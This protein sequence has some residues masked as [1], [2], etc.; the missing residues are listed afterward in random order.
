VENELR[1]IMK[2][3]GLIPK[4]KS[5]RLHNMVTNFLEGA[6]K[7]GY[8]T[9]TR[10]ITKST[11]VNKINVNNFNLVVSSGWASYVNKIINHYKVPNIVI[12][13]PQ[14][15]PTSKF[16]RGNGYKHYWG[17]CWN[18]PHRGYK[19]NDS[20]PNDRWLAL[21]KKY[22]IN[23]K[24]WRTNGNTIVIAHQP[25][26]G[27]DGESRTEFYD[28]IIQK[29]VKQSR[30]KRVVICVSPVGSGKHATNEQINSW[31]YM[32]CEVITSVDRGI[33]DNAWCFISSGGTTASKALFAG[34]PVYG[35]E[36]NITDPIR[37]K[38]S[39]DDFIKNPDTPDRT[40]WFNWIAYQQ[41]TFEEMINGLAFDYMMS[42]R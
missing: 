38:Q 12:F 26:L 28:D 21:K 30:K 23:I 19:Y 11:G 42:I 40:N 6:K 33:L 22:S 37:T 35:N 39:L 24:P 27:F 41:W 29:C 2:I 9:S 1:D 20:L 8:G 25:N 31:K 7:R 14:I 13:D 15:R 34:I 5:K 16:C 10:N 3:I 18:G 32:G 36:L 4:R 17:V